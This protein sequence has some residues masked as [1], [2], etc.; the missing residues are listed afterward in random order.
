IDAA[1]R[2]RALPLM[3]QAVTAGPPLAGLL[4]RIIQAINPELSDSVASV[5]LQLTPTYALR[6][7]TADMRQLLISQQ[8]DFSAAHR[9]HVPDLSDA[10]NQRLFGKCNNPAGHG[11]NYRLEVTVRAGADNGDEAGAVERLEELVDRNVIRRLDHKHLNEDV[12]QFSELNPSVENIARVVWEML[13]EPAATAG[14]PL[15]QVRIW[16]TEKTVCTYRG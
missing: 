7:D 13:Q 4:S 8:F 12:P 1:V 2:E 14:L 3:A 11:H 10:D 16:E 5:S 9:L 15:E 6:M